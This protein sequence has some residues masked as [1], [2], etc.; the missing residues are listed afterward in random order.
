MTHGRKSRDAFEGHR[1]SLEVQVSEHACE[2]FEVLRDAAIYRYI[3]DTPPA[4]V[5]RLAERLRLLEEG[6]SPDGK[7][8]WLNWAVRHPGGRLIGY[9]QSTVYPEQW[10]DVAYVLA[11]KFWGR[12]FAYQ[13]CSQMLDSLRKQHAVHTSYAITS[14][15]NARS[16][17][18]LIRLGFDQIPAENYPGESPTSSET[19]WRKVLV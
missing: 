1:V 2:L 9:V 5:E 14:V 7:E 17:R 12:G 19:V 10:A 11:S 6:R 3:D 18:L 4:S 15:E 16:K 13:A 8:L